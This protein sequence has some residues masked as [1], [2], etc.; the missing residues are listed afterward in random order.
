MGS[1]QCHWALKPPS[2]SPSLSLPKSAGSFLFFFSLPLS[3]AG[4]SLPFIRHLFSP[5]SLSSLPPLCVPLPGLWPPSFSSVPWSLCPA[6]IHSVSVVSLVAPSPVPST[7]TPPSHTHSLPGGSFPLYKAGPF[8]QSGLTSAQCLLCPSGLEPNEDRGT[9][10]PLSPGPASST[11][12]HCSAVSGSP[13]P[14]QLPDPTNSSQLHIPRRT[15]TQ[16]SATAMPP[17]SLVLF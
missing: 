2:P 12:P 4:F 14:P 16:N 7:P 13:A 8:I 1:L 9:S 6:S 15:G 5:P 11:G 3:Q 10:V 17:V